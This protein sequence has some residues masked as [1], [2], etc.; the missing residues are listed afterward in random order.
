MAKL[1]RTGLL[2]GVFIAHATV[3]G[4]DALR[5]EPPGYELLRVIE[6]AGRQGVATDGERYFVSGNT[7]LYVYSKSGELLVGNEAA[8]Q[9]LPRA[10]NHIGDIDVH[11]GELYAGVEFFEDGQG[12]DIQIAVYDAVTLRYRRSIP[13]EP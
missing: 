2:F 9:D 1:S 5:S 7:S 11:N 8:L 4:S 3:A 10:G 12:K 13:W 6:V